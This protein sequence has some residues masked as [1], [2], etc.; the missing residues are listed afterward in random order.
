MKECTVIT[1]AYRIPAVVDNDLVL[2]LD[3]GKIVQYDSPAQLIQDSSSAFSKLV[4]EFL[5]RSSTS[6][7]TTN[8]YYS[9]VEIDNRARTESSFLNSMVFSLIFA[10]D[11]CLSGSDSCT[12]SSS[13]KDQITTFYLM[14]IS[15][16]YV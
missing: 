3:Q 12:N 10:P 1:V 16:L 5:R 11:F 2:V 15:D 9:L 8:Y 7:M 4:A 6:M 13:C 14:L